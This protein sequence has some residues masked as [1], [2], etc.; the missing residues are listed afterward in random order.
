MDPNLN[1]AKKCTT[2]DK[3]Q[4][5]NRGLQSEENFDLRVSYKSL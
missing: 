5:S 4:T 3:R 1:R 2:N